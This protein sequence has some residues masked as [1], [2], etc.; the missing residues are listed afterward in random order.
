MVVRIVTG[1]GTGAVKAA[2]RTMLVSHPAVASVQSSLR[3]DAA[4]L[5][6]LKPPA[7]KRG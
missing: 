6:V 4:V 2:I 3:G 5:V 1:H 7:R